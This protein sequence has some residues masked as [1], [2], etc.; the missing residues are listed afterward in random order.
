MF[1][2]TAVDAQ[3]LTVSRVEQGREGEKTKGK[4]GGR[5][6]FNRFSHRNV[7]NTCSLLQTVG[8]NERILQSSQNKWQL[9]EFCVVDDNVKMGTNSL[10]KE[11][12]LLKQETAADWL[13]LSLSRQTVSLA[14]GGA[15]SEQD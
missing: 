15:S 3:L 2:Q 11:S 6:Q 9:S 10:F 12:A 14:A 4:G 7:R 5:Q 8:Y 13:E 1:P